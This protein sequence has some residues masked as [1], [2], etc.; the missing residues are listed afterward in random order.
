VSNAL[1]KFAP[2]ERTE[3]LGSRVREELRSAIMAGRFEPGEKLTLRAVADALEVSLTPAREALYNLVSEGALEVGPN[4]SVY[5]PKLDEARIGELTKIR[6]SLEGLAAKEAAANLDEETTDRIVA[7]N[8]AL[9]E[10]NRKGDYQRVITLNWKVH[11]GIYE[12]ARMPMLTRMIESCWLM[13][14]SYLNV[15]YPTF[16]EVDEGIRNHVAII[17]AVKAR[18][19]KAMSQAVCRDIRYAANALQAMIRADGDGK[20]RRPR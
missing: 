7:D 8:D 15:M 19:G 6:L 12:A 1:K 13:T 2:V 3:T 17:E 20:A 5:V 10:A 9:I 11:F 16:G 18:D 14:G 4:G